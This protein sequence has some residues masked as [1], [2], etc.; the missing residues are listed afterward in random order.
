M[1]RADALAALMLSP[2]VLSLIG[3]AVLAV[4]WTVR[5]E[6]RWRS[7]YLAPWRNADRA[8]GELPEE[9]RP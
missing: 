8:P 7:D 3:L 5:A 9:E 1:T 2:F 6:R 4:W